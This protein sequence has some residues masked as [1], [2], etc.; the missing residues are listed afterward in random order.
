MEG[1]LLSEGLG[2]QA[3]QAI[4]I[5]AMAERR[6]EKVRAEDD[7]GPERTGQG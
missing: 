2:R 1:T 7:R 3:V 4:R 6:L 5:S